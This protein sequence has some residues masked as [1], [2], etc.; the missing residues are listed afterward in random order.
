M[1]VRL[2]SS[3]PSLRP[4][5]DLDATA[6]RLLR[7]DPATGLT[8]L[9]HGPAVLQ[10][11]QDPLAALAWLDG[12]RHGTRP[13]AGYLS[14][15]LGTL[16]EPTCHSRTPV[17]HRPEEQLPLFAFGEIPPGDPLADLTPADLP[18][19]APPAED[20]PATGFRT[21]V[22]RAAYLRAVTRCVDYIRA[23]DIF[24]VNLSQQFTVTTDEPAARLYDRLRHRFPA[25]YGGLLDFGDFAL[26][27]NS[28]ELFLR[29]E[30]DGR[31]VTRP[32]KGTRPNRPGM[33]QELTASEKD[34]AELN[35][36][37][38]LE[39]NDLGRVC[40]IGSVRVTQPRTVEEHP[41]VFHGVA[42]VEGQLNPGVGLVE[43]L[44]ATFPGGSITGAPKIRAMQ[45][46]DELEPHRRGAYCGSQGVLWPDGGLTLSVAIRTMT[47]R[48]GAVHVP[49]GGGIVADSLPEA[50]YEETLV[51]ARAMLETLGVP[52]ADILAATA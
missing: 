17:P 14:Y 50:E 21:C 43:L 31:V 49:A 42:T 19:A 32:I 2:H 6:T 15:E 29:V 16:F 34:A 24:Q 36:I 39:R 23:G 52:P 12:Q 51:K 35:M 46:I 7:H 27:S 33:R 4:A 28:P 38:D 37:V 41:T 3:D 9:F 13:W 5:W 11:W 20:P 18:P 45:I 48:G 22:T 8:H 30:P 44:A 25:A 40:R 26:L 10:T 47:A 1:R